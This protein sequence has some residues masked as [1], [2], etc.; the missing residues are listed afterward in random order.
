[1]K[2]TSWMQADY[3][4]VGVSEKEKNGISMTETGFLA[5]FRDEFS[6]HRD[7]AMRR[8]DGAKVFVAEIKD[9]RI[10]VND[11]ARYCELIKEWAEKKERKNDGEQERRSRDGQVLALAQ[12]QEQ[13]RGGPPGVGGGEARASR[14]RGE[15]PQEGRRLRREGVGGRDAPRPEEEG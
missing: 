11:M 5:Y 3:V 1:M 7:A 8:I 15:D 4:V 2:S 13:L 10:S 14:A 9:G 12:R 6:A